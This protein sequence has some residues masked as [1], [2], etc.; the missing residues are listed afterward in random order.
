MRRDLADMGEHRHAT[1]GGLHRRPC[2][3][4]LLV[5]GQGV[6]LAVGAGT[7]DAVTGCRLTLDLP[8]EGLRR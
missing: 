8:D 3:Q 7:E 4:H 5:E 1:G 2:H 6:E